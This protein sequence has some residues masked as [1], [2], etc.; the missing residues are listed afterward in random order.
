VGV[1]GTSAAHADHIINSD[2]GGD[3]AAFGTWDSATATCTLTRDLNEPVVLVGFGLTLDGNGHSI[4]GPGGGFGVKCDGLLPVEGACGTVTIQNLTVTGF[5]IGINLVY[6]AGTINNNVISGN[7]LGIQMIRRGCRT[8]TNNIIKDNEIALYTLGVECDVVANNRFADNRTLFQFFDLAVMAIYN[9]NFIDNG[10][11]DPSFVSF[12]GQFNLPS[13]TG[14]NYWSEF[15]LPAQGCA[16]LNRDGFCDAPFPGV[17][18]SPFCPG[19]ERDNLPWTQPNGW[20]VLDITNLI[21]AKDRACDLGWISKNGI[22]N[23]LGAKLQAAKASIE[24][25]RFDTAANQLGAFLNQLRAQDGK[26]V[27]HQAYVLLAT[28]AQSL[29]DK[30]LP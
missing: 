20:F 22:C 9:N 8:I 3:C 27:N 6:T 14:G 7:K 2:T 17:F 26:A 19:C 18:T 10:P 28:A 5:G 13:P 11:S 16:D 25:G 23:G 30:L 21:A 1:L 4:V 12:F 15:H 29:I 24:R